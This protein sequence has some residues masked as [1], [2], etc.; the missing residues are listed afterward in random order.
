MKK[1]TSLLV[2]NF[3]IIVGNVTQAQTF[4]P[5]GAKWHY[6]VAT[7]SLTGINQGLFIVESTNSVQF[8]GQTY[9]VISGGSTLGGDFQ[10]W[11]REENEKVYIRYGQPSIEV[12][13]FDK[14]PT[15]G[16]VWFFPF[17]GNNS[18]SLLYYNYDTA[19]DINT[20]SVSLTVTAVR[21]TT[22]NNLPAKVIEVVQKD[23]HQ[24]DEFG[25]PHKIFTPFGMW[26]TFFILRKEGF[27]DF[28]TPFG[29]RCYEDPYWG[30]IN[31]EPN[32]ACDSIS[33]VGI[34][35]ISQNKFSL[36]PNPANESLNI[37]F[38]EQ[39]N[40]NYTIC[41]TDIHGKLIMSKACE[42][43]SY[44]SVISLNNYTPGVYF[45]HLVKNNKRISTERFVKQ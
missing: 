32:V 2:F 39:V 9:N 11:V 4:A 31:F 22:F 8:Q 28:N 6:R 45:L 16:D 20:D 7:Q 25:G 18:I 19:T 30:L 13:F 33:T 14:N 42:I 27:L 1:I 3:L 41:I 37:H 29:L 44:N 38:K 35:D 23:S 34:N 26:T 21:D 43:D 24:N 5:L 17:D 15:V 12:L 10:L 36:F 40:Q